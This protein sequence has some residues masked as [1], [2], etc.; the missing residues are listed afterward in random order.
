[1]RALR[2][3]S[4]WT[5]VIFVDVYSIACSI[6]PASIDDCGSSNMSLLS[7][8]LQSITIIKLCT[9]FTMHR[10]IHMYK[11]PAQAH[12][13]CYSKMTSRSDHMTPQRFTHH[14]CS[15]ECILIIIY[16]KS[17]E[18]VRLTSSHEM[19]AVLYHKNDWKW[20]VYCGAKNSSGYNPLISH[21]LLI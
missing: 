21:S 3:E 9:L 20:P 4:S 14:P 6:P 5:V 19:N 18:I 8:S 16:A 12:F 15:L 7:K 2:S 13:V 10:I 17:W 11:L 1:M